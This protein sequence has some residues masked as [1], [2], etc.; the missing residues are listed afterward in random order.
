MGGE[1][2]ENGTCI[3]MDESLCCSPE[4][5]AILLIRLHPNTKKNIFRYFF[6]FCCLVLFP[7]LAPFSVHLP[8]GV[9]SRGVCT[10]YIFSDLTTIF[11][12]QRCLKKLELPYDS[13]I[14]LLGIYS[15]KTIIQK[16]ICTHMFTAALF[17][18]K[19]QRYYFANKDPFSQ[20]YVFSSSHVRMS[21]LDYKE[22]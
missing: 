7:F 21:E 10:T 17:T 5:V 12:V 14:P 4:T 16:D 20:S 1:F 9:N 15:D 11:T 22:D 3:R 18:I 19:K 13:A 8:R 6:L 2:G